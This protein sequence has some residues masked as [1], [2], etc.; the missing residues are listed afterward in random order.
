VVLKSGRRVGRGRGR[1]RKFNQ[2][3]LDDLVPARAHNNGVL[4][5]WREAYAR[6]PL[7]VA[8]L[9][10]GVFAVTKGVPELDCSITRARHNL[11]VVG[12]E[13]DR[14]DIASVADESSSGGTRRQLPQA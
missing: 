9:G 13:G 6:H 4:W 10:D 1:G 14:Q 7:G 5:V 2:T 12:G 11:T 8:L 3:Y